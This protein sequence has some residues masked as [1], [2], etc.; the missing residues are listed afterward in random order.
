VGGNTQTFA[1]PNTYS[2]TTTVNGGTLLI[3]GTHS[4]DAL[5]NAYPGGPM[6]AAN[7]PP[8]GDYTVNA[9]GTLGGT[10][11]I[12]SEADPVN[13]NVVG[14][15]VNPGASVGT[16]TVEGG[17]NFDATSQFG[18]EISGSTVDKL[19]AD[20]L[21]IA[22]GAI[23]DVLPLGNVTAGQ[24]TIA[25]FGSRTGTFTL[26]A[27]AGFSVAYNANN[28]MLTAPN[29]SVGV[30]GDYNGNGVVDAADYTYWRDRLGQNLTLPQSDPNDT[31]GVVTTAEYN[32][33]KSRFGAT[34]GSASSS[35]SGNQAVPEPA[36]L[37]LSMLAVVA[38]L[39]V[40]RRP[41]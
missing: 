5:Q 26:N 24:Y 16:L 15:T 17:A 38:W 29:I 11:S 32:F 27:P 31:D 6:P 35:L 23:L 18:V 13:V 8:V 40:Y 7:A 1:G 14:G 34:S 3:N 2:G 41:Q 19:I 12:G 22:S 33:W 36:S 28:I 4:R 25:E 39:G 10:G 21:N 30:A 20:S 37:A 9:G